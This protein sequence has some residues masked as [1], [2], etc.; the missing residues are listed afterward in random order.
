MR[1]NRPSEIPS[2]TFRR[3]M[4]RRVDLGLP[5]LGLAGRTSDVFGGFWPPF[6]SV[7]SGIWRIWGALLVVD[8]VNCFA[9]SPVS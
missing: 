3:A 5:S 4:W 7:P 1:Y 8:F 6:R 9:I 2:S